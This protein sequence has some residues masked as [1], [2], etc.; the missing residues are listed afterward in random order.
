MMKTDNKFSNVAA[1][2]ERISQKPPFVSC[3]SDEGAEVSPKCISEENH[4]ELGQRNI[5]A[6]PR[7]NTGQ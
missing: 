7:F 4:I 3:H 6:N 5:D 1:T 2:R